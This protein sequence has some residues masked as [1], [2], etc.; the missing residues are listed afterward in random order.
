VDIEDTDFVDN[1]YVHDAFAL[2][3]SSPLT[4][5]TEMANSHNS[6]SSSLVKSNKRSEFRNSY[7]MVPKIR[8]TNTSSHN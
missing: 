5:K 6:N 8:G 7:A 3:N 2:C 4:K 1:T